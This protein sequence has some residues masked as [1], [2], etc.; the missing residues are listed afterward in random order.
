MLA[1]TGQGSKYTAGDKAMSLMSLNVVWGIR[2][3]FLL[4]SITISAQYVHASRLGLV[5]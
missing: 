1:A 3:Q 2:D 4:S 5:T